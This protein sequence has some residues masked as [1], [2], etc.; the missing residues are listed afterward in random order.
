M[1]IDFS[2]CPNNLEDAARAKTLIEQGRSGCSAHPSVQHGRPS[3]AVHNLFPTR[4]Q[5]LHNANRRIDMSF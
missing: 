4:Y 3:I 1:K 2:Y 5:F